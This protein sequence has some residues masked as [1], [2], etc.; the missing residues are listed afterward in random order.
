[1]SKNKRRYQ[2]DGYDLDLAYITDHI[3]AMGAPSQGSRGALLQAYQPQ[4]YLIMKAAQMWFARFCIV[5]E[6]LRA[7]VIGLH[8]EEIVWHNQGTL[9]V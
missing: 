7:D 4:V 2:G 8:C 5:F 9:P 6:A 3:I 1:M